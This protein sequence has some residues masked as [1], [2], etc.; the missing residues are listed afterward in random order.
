MRM[1]GGEVGIF[2]F[3]PPQAILPQAEKTS[4]H[5]IFWHV[6]EICLSTGPRTLDGKA[7]TV[8]ALIEGRPPEHNQ[9]WTRLFFGCFLVLVLVADPLPIAGNR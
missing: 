6:L 4:Y 3:M 9:A 1:I 8:A 7:R 2:R 5:Q